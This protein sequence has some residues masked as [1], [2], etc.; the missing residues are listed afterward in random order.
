M[1]NT[2]MDRTGNSHA[3]KA[4]GENFMR[5]LCCVVGEYINAVDWNVAGVNRVGWHHC[6]SQSPQVS[7]LDL[8]LWEAKSSFSP[9]RKHGGAGEKTV[10]DYG[11]QSSSKKRV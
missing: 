9:R 4:R 11:C 10:S 6:L 2:T 8:A 5:S 3:A 7:R 1:A